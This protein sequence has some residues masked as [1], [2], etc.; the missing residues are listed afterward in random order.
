MGGDQAVTGTLY[1]LG[2]GPGDPDLITLKALRL[3]RQAPVV[4]YP[5]PEEGE[6]LA[7]SI[8]AP[9]LPGGQIEFVIRMPL[10]VERFPA[11]AVYDAAAEE[12][13]WHLD[14]GRD[15]ALLCEGDPFVYGSFQYLFGRLAAGHGGGHRGGHR[16][17][18]VPGVSSLTACGARLGMPLA[19]RND[20]FVVLPG[21]LPAETLRA[22]LAESD[23]AAI[24]K[25]G[26]HFA[27]VRDVLAELGLLESARYI[28][29]A[30]MA[31]E[32]VVPP[33]SVDPESVPYFSMILVHRRG[34]AW[35]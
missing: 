7:R 8:V 13:G 15:V 31:Q 22:R 23:A 21:P 32:R 19:A 12:I 27:K 30:T 24:I 3:L 16:I 18:V 28:E 20:T 35:R 6:S 17:E 9:H 5:A 29:R 26:R 25:L 4:A 2:V 1:G 11:Q 34:D 10:V 14:Q 33:A